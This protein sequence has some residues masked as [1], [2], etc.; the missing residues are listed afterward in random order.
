[1]QTRRHIEELQSLRGVA[2]LV[3]AISHMSSVYA[4]PSALRISIDALLNAHASLIVFFVLSGYVLTGSLMRRGLTWSSVRSFYLGRLFR[5][6]PA[7]WAASAIAGLLL[8]FFPPRAIPGVTFWFAIYLEAVPT[9]PKVILAAFAI[10]KCLVMPVWTIFIELMG[11]ALMPLMV[12][13]ALVRATMFPWLVFGMGC[14]T[15]FLARAPHRLDSLGYMFD[16]ALGVL[17][18]SRSWKFFADGLS[19]KLP[20]AVFLLVFFRFLWFT[21]LRGHPIPLYDGYDD[22]LPTLVEGVAAFFVVGALS[23]ERGRTPILRGRVATWLGDVSYSLYLIHFPVILLTAKLISHLSANAWAATTSA[24]VLIAVALPIALFLATL[25][26]RYIELPG[27]A[28]GRKADLRVPHPT[29][30]LRRVGSQV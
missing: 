28:W 12:R 20:A 2:A 1:V 29:S 11:S 26:Y 13:W 30:S 9:W 4:I 17:L 21:V 10:D 5:L 15:Y 25:L 18:A 22:P 16:F 14:G 7:L 3:V 19:F 27:I 24:A 8:W 23:S 6:F